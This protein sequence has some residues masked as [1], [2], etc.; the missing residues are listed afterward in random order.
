[1]GALGEAMHGHLLAGR[2]DL[3]P[4]LADTLVNTVLQGWSPAQES[5]R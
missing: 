4:E 2:P 5:R 1:M 3:T